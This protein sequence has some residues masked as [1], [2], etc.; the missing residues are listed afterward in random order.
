MM[1]LN[2]LSINNTFSQLD[3]RKITIKYTQKLNQ[4]YGNN[5]YKII[6]FANHSTCC[7]Q[8]LHAD[9][10]ISPKATT[11]TWKYLAS[12][13]VDKI[14]TLFKRV[15]FNKAMTT[16]FANDVNFVISADIIRR[17]SENKEYQSLV[18][19]YVV[20]MELCSNISLLLYLDILG[21][22]MNWFME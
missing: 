19:D 6:A 3:V 21:K 15:T 9:I 16:V 22:G 13:I 7:L 4:K 20:D 17:I 14:S 8:G 2:F 1:K 18:S 5:P 10:N 11:K 12:Y